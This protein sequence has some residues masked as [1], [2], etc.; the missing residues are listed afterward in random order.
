MLEVDITSGLF[1]LTAADFLEKNAVLTIWQG[2]VAQRYVSG[3]VS[4]VALGKNN[5]WQMRYHLGIRPPLWRAELRQNYRIFQ[6][7]DIKTILATLLN[8]AG[9]AD[10]LPLFYEDHP[11][12]ESC[13]QYGE[14]DLG[15][16]TRLW[17]EEG[18]SSSGAAGR[19]G[20]SRRWRCVMTWRG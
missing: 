13:V 3:F 15:F 14:T 16:L 6:Q 9:V 2:D 19:K 10:W 4:E 7:Q 8:E 11:T 18:C 1:D 12:R 17:A 5:G 20:R